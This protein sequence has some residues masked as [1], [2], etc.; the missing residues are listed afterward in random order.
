MSYRHPGHF[1]QRLVPALGR[2]ESTRHDRYAVAAVL[3]AD[4]LWSPVMR[5]SRWCFAPDRA[6]R[7]MSKNVLFFDML[8]QGFYSVLSTIFGGNR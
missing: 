6:W 3:G 5:Q 4:R 8:W 2:S 7:N 1:S